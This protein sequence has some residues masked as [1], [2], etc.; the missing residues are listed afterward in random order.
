[1]TD[2]GEQHGRAVEVARV[3]HPRFEHR[4]AEL[5]L[6]LRRRA[7]RDHGAG[8][9]HDD[10]V[11]EVLGLV[12]VLGREQHGCAAGDQFLDERPDIVA[13]AWVQTRRRLVEEQDGR[14]GNQA[15][16]D[17]QTPTHPARVGLDQPVTSVDEIEAL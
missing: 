12:H 13:R 9:D 10:L 8:I 3:T 6:E 14:P 2:V 4:P 17:I 5:G 1:M 11:S 15:R 7:V 16:T